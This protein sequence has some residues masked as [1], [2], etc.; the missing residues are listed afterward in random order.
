MRVA[1]VGNS[2]AGLARLSPILIL[3]CFLAGCGQGPGEAVFFERLRAH[4]APQARD[5]GWMTRGTARSGALSCARQALAAR[6]PFFVSFEGATVDSALRTGLAFDGKVSHI[7]TWDSDVWG[8][9]RFL[10]QARLSVEP[11]PLPVLG[12]G[13]APIRCPAP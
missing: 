5:C 2:G 3:A 1:I 9:S 11:C 12:E 10:R 7:L 4:A 8:G 13:E 6:E